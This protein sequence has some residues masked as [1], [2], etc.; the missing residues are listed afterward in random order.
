MWTLSKLKKRLFLYISIIPVLFFF[1]LVSTYPFIYG[2][3]LG[4]HKVNLLYTRFWEIG[5]A[6]FVGL[7]NFIRAFGMYEFIPSLEFTFLFG[8]LAPALEFFLGL[9]LALLANREIKGL[10][11]IKSMLLMPLMA[12][13]VVAGYMWKII[14]RPHIG[15]FNFFLQLLGMKEILLFNSLGTARAFVVLIDVWQN[16]PFVFLILLSGLMS[17]PREP[18]EA[19]QLDGASRWKIF[20]HITLPLLKPL[21]LIALIFRVLTAFG[22]YDLIYVLTQGRPGLA[23]YAF[24]YHIYVVSFTRYE[25]GLGAA[26]GWVLLL[27]TLVIAQVFVR[28]LR[29]G[30]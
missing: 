30:T 17:L 4:L 12:T 28:S 20:V 10:T 6:Q 16:T 1:N 8:A 29:G 23:T 5:A 2:I 14:A 26:L 21:I 9:G 27:I 7:Q 15:L 24:T 3:Y 18:Y 22:S 13:P 25:F 19:A 11:I